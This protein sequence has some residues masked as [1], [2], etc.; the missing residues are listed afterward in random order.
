MSTGQRGLRAVVDSGRHSTK[1]KMAIENKI[2]LFFRSKKTFE[3]FVTFLLNLNHL[4]QIE[5]KEKKERFQ[6]KIF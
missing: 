3:G 6:G 1:H 4:W 5:P 2:G